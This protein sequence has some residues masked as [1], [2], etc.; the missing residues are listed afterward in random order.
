MK[1][2]LSKIATYEQRKKIPTITINMTT[3]SDFGHH[4]KSKNDKWSHIYRIMKMLIQ[5]IKS[6]D[7]LGR[8]ERPLVSLRVHIH[9][10]HQHGKIHW[11]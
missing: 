11:C 8:P 9:K 4:D 3:A 5:N 2:L 1:L 6:T 7:P 10:I